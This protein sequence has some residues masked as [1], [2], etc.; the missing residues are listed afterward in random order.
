VNA[1]ES[2]CYSCTKQLG[3]KNSVLCNIGNAGTSKAYVRDD[4]GHVELINRES[5]LETLQ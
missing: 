2:V 4:S 5:V 1:E 3:T